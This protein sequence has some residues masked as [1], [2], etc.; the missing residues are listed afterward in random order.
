MNYQYSKKFFIGYSDVDKNDKCKLNKIVDLLQNTATMHSKSVGY[1]TKEMMNL[2]QAW[3]MLGWRVKIIKFP[4]A[5]M[6]VEVRTWSRG[7]KTFEAKRGYE[8]YS[9]DGELLI[10]ADSNWALF[11]L[12]KQKLIRAPQEMID[13]YGAIDRDVF[14]GEKTEKLRD[15][16]I[17]E[18]EI[19]V[20]VGKRD[21]DT[22]NHMNNS[23]YLEYIIEVLPDNLEI[24]E[25]ECVYRKQIP[26]GEQI[27]ISYGEGMCRIKNSNNELNFL[28][29]IK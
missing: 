18:N 27:N 19:F 25:F 11:D 23:K 3:L 24:S 2:K 10:V 29:K 28:L 17:V 6:D 5:D 26:F 12:E 16:E 8:I 13:V 1:G 22:N 20:E 14:E 4:E 7:I 9:E 21:I 15:N